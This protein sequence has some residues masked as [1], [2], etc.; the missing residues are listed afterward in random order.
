MAAVVHALLVYF[1]LFQ[2][3]VFQKTAKKCTTNYNAR[4]QPLNY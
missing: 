2:V 4:A 3:F 1:K